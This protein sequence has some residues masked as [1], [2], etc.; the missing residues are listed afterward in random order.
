MNVAPS[1]DAPAPPSATPADS[2]AA[3]ALSRFLA[4]ALAPVAAALQ[5]GP[6][7]TE[8]E[9]GLAEMVLTFNLDVGPLP[10]FKVRWGFGEGGQ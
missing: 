2:S 1:S 6:T 9:R 10:A 3:Q 8:G 7:R 4:A 5:L